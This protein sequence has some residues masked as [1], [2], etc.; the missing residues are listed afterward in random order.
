MILGS[1]L[2]LGFIIIVGIQVS[3]SVL[4]ADFCYA[5][6]DNAIL[7]AGENIGLD[8]DPLS[9][10]TYYTT[11]E[12][13]N[14][15]ND[16]FNT[17]EFALYQLNRTASSSKAFCDNTEMNNIGRQTSTTV[18]TMDSLQ[19]SMSCATINPLCK[20]RLS[21]VTTHYLFLPPSRCLVES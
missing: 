8:D 6:P 9:L 19:D 21:C 7:L 18:A 5:N 16:P 17:T 11:C 10:V 3:V 2:L 4:I 15:M 1:I 12:G 14:P 20:F 13:Q